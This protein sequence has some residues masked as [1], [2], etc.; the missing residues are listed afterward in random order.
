VPRAQDGR[1]ATIVVKVECEDVRRR[2]RS[3]S[4]T[5]PGFV[6]MRVSLRGLPSAAA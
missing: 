3:L 1:E 2:L 6:G 5:G 4:S